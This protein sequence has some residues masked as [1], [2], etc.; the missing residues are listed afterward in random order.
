LSRPL[1]AIIDD[2][3]GIRAALRMLM[4]SASYGVATFASAE[5]FVASGVAGSSSCII[6]DANMP[7]MS[8]FDLIGVLKSEGCTAPVIVISALPDDGLEQQAAY[9]GARCFLRKPFESAVLVSAVEESLM[10]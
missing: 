7:G 3:A 8:G 4:R 6:T 10:Q 9:H 2:D 5:A 1:I